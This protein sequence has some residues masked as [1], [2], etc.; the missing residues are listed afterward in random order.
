MP[1]SL[2]L[3]ALALPLLLAGGTPAQTFQGLDTPPPPPKKPKPSTSSTTKPASATQ[4]SGQQGLGLDLTTPA[5]PPAKTDL[6]M[7][8]PPPSKKGTAPTTTFEALDVS[9]RTADRQRLEAANASFQ[10]G[11]Y[12][13]AAL[14]A[15][16][17]MNDP[18]MAPLQLESQYLLGKTLYRMGQYHSALGEFSQ[19]LARGQDTRFFSKSLEW[20]FFISHKTVNESV[21]LD[22]VARYANAQWPE[23]YQ[24]EFHY[25]LARYYFVRGR[26]LDTVEQKGEAA[27]SFEE[28]RKLTAQIP[29]SDRFYPPGQVPRG[30]HLDPRPERTPGAGGDEGGGPG[31]AARAG[32]E[33]GG[34]ED[35]G[36][37]P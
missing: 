1:R 26:A 27:K 19:I 15:W 9:G 21:I 7:P 23:R 25:L 24:D 22:E 4:T 3:V 6:P 37:D 36:R 32:S 13:K 12:D 8:P 33:R 31:D 35:R 29:K 2:R 10:R 5:P 34:R 30:A 28:T 20:L 17:L 16:E 11:E 14:A 18:K